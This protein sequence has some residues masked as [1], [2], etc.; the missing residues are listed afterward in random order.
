MRFRPVSDVTVALRAD[1]TLELL[2]RHTGRRVV[3][4]EPSAAMW[5]ALRQ[6]NGDV[7]L[8]AEALA[9]HWNRAPDQLR[10][11]L[12]DFVEELCRARLMLPVQDLGPPA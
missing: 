11:N 6:H 4:D 8:A 10:R 9:P 7:D 2:V 12:A 1:G 3:I 5:M